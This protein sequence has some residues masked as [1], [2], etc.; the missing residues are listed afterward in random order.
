MRVRARGRMES[1]VTGTEL[2][3]KKDVRM[4]IWGVGGFIH[5]DS[6]KAETKL[7]SPKVFFICYVND[8]L[9]NCH[10]CILIWRLIQWFPI[11][12]LI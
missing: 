7:V 4:G 12:I 9:K 10:M 8:L 3:F 6:S 2:S 1:R 5:L 11:N